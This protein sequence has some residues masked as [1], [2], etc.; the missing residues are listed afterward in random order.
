MSLKITVDFGALNPYER[1]PPKPVSFAL[2]QHSFYC[3]LI[4]GKESFRTK[5]IKISNPIRVEWN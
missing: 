2:I 5:T 4:L 1:K 3:V